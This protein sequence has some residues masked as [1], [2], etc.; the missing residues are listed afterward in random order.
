M[1]AARAAKSAAR[2]RATGAATGDA[3]HDAALAVRPWRDLLA[4]VPLLAAYELAVASAGGAHR[5]SSELLLSFPL[6]PL[7]PNAQ[8]VARS[9]IFAAFA[10]VAAGRLY[11]ARQPL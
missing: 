4:C 7:G 1:S 3:A 8:L 10:V 5:N 6:S 2:E 11:R 9:G